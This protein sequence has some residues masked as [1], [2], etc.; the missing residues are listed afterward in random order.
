MRRLTDE[1][2]DRAAAN[3]GLVYR[4]G[5]DDDEIQIAAI[6]LMRAVQDHDPDKG[7]LS[8]YAMRWAK[9]LVSRHRRERSLIHVPGYRFYREARLERFKAEIP[10]VVQLDGD[11]AGRDATTR[12]VD[13]RDEADRLLSGLDRDEAELVRRCLM[14]G[15]LLRDVAPT[16]G[17][18]V[19]T[20]SRTI[21][22]A[23]AA[24]RKRLKVDVDGPGPSRGEKVA[25]RRARAYELVVMRGLSGARAG[26]LM[27]LTR[28][29]VS[30][31]VIEYK[32]SRANRGESA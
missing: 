25:E 30:Q 27:G 26:K 7:A 11:V 5:L 21:Q 12:D 6:G 1:E 23:I 32:E 20:A 28:G 24:I 31:L 9:S 17:M 2:R 29:R 15:E 19:S 13:A 16:L 22:G 10:T 8:T 3:L 18:S 14:G 4:K